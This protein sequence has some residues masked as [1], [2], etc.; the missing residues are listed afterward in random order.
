MV[1]V[2]SDQIRG[3]VGSCLRDPSP[4]ITHLPSLVCFILLSVFLV[5]TDN[6][7]LEQNFSD[8]HSLLVKL[9]TH[10]FSY[11]HM[12][13]MLTRQKHTGE[14]FFWTDMVARSK[15]QTKPVYRWRKSAWT[16]PGAYSLSKSVLTPLLLVQLAQMLFHAC[17]T[18]QEAYYLMID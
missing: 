3:Q 4:T 14:P 5:G 9:T 12:K 17:K 13:Q 8:P 15:G 7:S 18:V 16:W 2:Y 11:T 6:E 1:W 10:T